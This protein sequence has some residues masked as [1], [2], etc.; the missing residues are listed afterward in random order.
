M[1]GC[2]PFGW[3]D[4]SSSSVGPVAP[5]TS[6]P[7]TDPASS[8]ALAR[9]YGQ[10]PTWI[11]CG[12]GFSCAKVSVPLDWAEPAGPSIHLAMIRK[13]ATGERRGS[14]FVN[15][16]GPGASG[17]GFLRQAVTEFATVGAG[18]DLVSW[19][20]RGIGA[21]DPVQCLPNSALD[22]YYAVDLTPDT[23][24]ERETAISETKTYISA[25]QANTGALLRHLDTI[26][27]AKDMDVLR[28]VVGDSAFTYLGGSYG[29]YLGAW[30]AQ[31]FPWRVGR[32]V[33][34]GAVDPS[35]TSAQYGEGQAQ[36]FSRA[37]QSYVDDCLR[38]SGCPLRG[39]RDEAYAQLDHLMTRADSIPLRT[40]GSRQLT[41]ALLITGLLDGMYSRQLWPVVTKA[42][43]AAFTGDGSVMLALADQYL[44][45]GADGTYGQTLQVTGP[46]YCLDHGDTRSVDAIAADAVRLK[47]AYPPF[48]DVLGWGALGCALWPY[49]QVVPTQKLTAVG[50]AP[51]LVV[52]TTHDP[53]TPYEWA[54][55]LATQLSSGRLLTRRG[56]GHTGYKQGSTCTDSVIEK[57]LLDG[58]VPAA[59]VTC[60]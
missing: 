24:A 3:G 40:G 14:L 45:R 51:I 21:S 15:P 46:I 33:L 23:A 55:G 8:A 38:Q 35:L 22:A 60:G 41:Q 29:S 43:T 5:A 42:L 12:A 17:V 48:G 47:K 11:D 34:D 13:P 30:Y 52:G 27:T 4:G 57:Y 7:A 39:T 37:V 19:D 26:S 31:L 44:E 58:V 20:P 1:A 54:Q 36:G 49:P 2:T 18:F 32:L 25:C 28:A 16:G 10:K 6:P 56:E 9:F 53:A 50:A 59:D